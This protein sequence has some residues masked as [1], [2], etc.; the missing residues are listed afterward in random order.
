MSE[1]RIEQL[2]TRA[3]GYWES[4]HQIPLDLFAEMNEAGLDVQALEDT[5]LTDEE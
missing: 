3:R 5:Y 2:I 4:G 1:R